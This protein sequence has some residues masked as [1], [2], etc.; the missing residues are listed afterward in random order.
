MNVAILLID[1]HAHHVL[2]CAG[3][4]HVQTPA[5][6][7]L[8]A[9]GLRFEQAVCAVTPC[10][11]SRHAISHGLYA[12]LT[13]IYTN[14]LCMPLDAIP[15]LTMARVFK[16][17]GHCTAAIGK[18]NWFPYHA[19]VSRGSYFGYDY[20]AAHFNE[21][22]IILTRTLLRNTPILSG[23]RP[24]NGRRTALVWAATTARQ[25]A[26][27][28]RVATFL[29]PN[30]R[31]VDRRAGRYLGAST[32]RCAVFPDAQLPRSARPPCGAVRLCGS[33]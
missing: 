24:P 20:R 29:G 28:T 15:P 18:M 19:P 11:P 16:D 26:R 23:K 10:L 5:A 21:T 12:F 27:G 8:A 2:G 1:Q 30:E 4:P 13:G 3:F 14:G 7:A 9:E 22:A 33:L 31:W 6:D 32:S 25:P 17:A